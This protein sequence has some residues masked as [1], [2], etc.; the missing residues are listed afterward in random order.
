MVQ[1]TRLL[2]SLTN[3]NR[4]VLFYFS[5]L[6]SWEQRKGLDGGYT[7]KGEM[8]KGLLEGRDEVQSKISKV[9]SASGLL[10]FADGCAYV[11]KIKFLLSG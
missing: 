8:D 10:N 11:L 6:V 1:I 3:A 9:S 5:K 7:P 2:P 4:Q